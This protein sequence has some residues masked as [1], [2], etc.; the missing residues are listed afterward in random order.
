MQVLLLLSTIKIQL[1]LAITVAMDISLIMH[2]TILAI[3]QLPTVRIKMRIRSTLLPI[4]INT[5]K[6]V[7]RITMMAIHDK[8]HLLAQPVIPIHTTPIN[9]IIKTNTEP[10]II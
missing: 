1:S 4:P 2:T 8:L 6:D 9:L 10:I 3:Q 7:I 5:H